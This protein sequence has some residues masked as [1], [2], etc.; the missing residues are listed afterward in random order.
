MDPSSTST[1]LIGS[2]LEKAALVTPAQLQVALYDQTYCGSRI[3]EILSLRGWIKQETAD[4]FAE[5]WPTIMDEPAGIPIGACLQQAFLVTSEQIEEAIQS[6]TSNGL[7]IGAIF[8]LNGWLKQPT[9][10]F[11]LQGLAPQR[12]TESPFVVK[13]R[14][15]TQPSLID[16]PRQQVTGPALASD[17]HPIETETP[18]VDTETD[19][20]EDFDWLG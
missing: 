12:V 2:F 18:T 15:T 1:T 8:V 9:V 13:P 14:T 4:F 11:F 19:D 5:Q 17:L 16:D 6:Q 3:G 10:D 7:R 20:D